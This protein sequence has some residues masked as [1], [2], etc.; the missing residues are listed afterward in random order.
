MNHQ[1]NCIFCQ[2]VRGTIPAHRVHEDEE[3]L[4]FMDIFPVADGHTLIIPR[5]HRENIFEITADEIGA[6]GRVSRR[7]GLAIRQAFAPE[8][9]M[10]FQLNGAAAGQTVFH[11]HMHFMPRRE[12]EP[13]ALHTRVAGDPARLA[14]NARRIAA[15]L[16][17]LE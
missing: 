7:I 8:G 9:L 4:V 15:A 5:A 2:I 16:E 17:T 10:V 14:E 6:I 3:T 1:E 11:Y 13:L 12:G